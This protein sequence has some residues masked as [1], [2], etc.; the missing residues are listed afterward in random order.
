LLGGIPV[1]RTGFLLFCAT[2][3]IAARSRRKVKPP[4][5]AISACLDQRLKT[6]RRNGAA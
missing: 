4:M 2:A 3:K 6:D 1:D 5:Q